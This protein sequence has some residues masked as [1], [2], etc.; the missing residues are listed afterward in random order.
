MRCTF[1]L[2]GSITAL[3][4]YSTAATAQVD[5]NLQVRIENLTPPKDRKPDLPQTEV[6]T[7]TRVQTYTTTETVA[8][9][10]AERRRRLQ[11]ILAEKQL[12]LP[13][14]AE[15][16]QRAYET[17]GIKAQE[18]RTVQKKKVI[19]E[20]VVTTKPRE[21]TVTASVSTQSVFD[22]NASKTPIHVGDTVFGT[23]GLLTVNI[24][25]GLADSFILQSGVSDQRYARLFTKNVDILVNNATYNQ[26]LN[27][28]V[29]GKTS[30]TTTSDVMSYSVASNTVYGSGF[31][32]YQ[33]ELFTPS[34]AWAR[35]NQDLAGTICGL[36][37]QEAFCVAGTF[38]AEGE[39]TFS[40]IASQ[41]NFSSRL[42]GGVTWQTPVTG[43]TTSAGGYVQGRHFTDFPGGRDDLI[44][45]AS[46]RADWTPNSYVQLSAVLQVTQQFSTVKVLEWN[47]FAAYPYVK[48]RVTF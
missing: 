33:V 13:A 14:D 34:I 47:G 10:P 1:I 2:L 26:V 18:T 11:K 48:L 37:G 23:T 43:L 29:P 21:T 39:F 7:K 30:G 22:N 46:A 32:P 19:T 31:R 35:N 15:A 40:D 41:Q 25:V 3:A 17:Y 6:V 27:L 42:S 44:L 28:V 38:V 8:V 16:V 5:P 20:H 24:P 9:P 45:Q 4:G 36:K 12:M